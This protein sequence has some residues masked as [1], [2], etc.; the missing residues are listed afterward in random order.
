MPAGKDCD[1][2]HEAQ[3]V[4][5]VRSLKPPPQVASEAPGRSRLQ[6]S[7][8]KSGQG[9]EDQRHVFI[10]YS[11]NTQDQKA[12]ELA[13]QATT[14]KRTVRARCPDS[15][16]PQPGENRLGGVLARG[17][18]LRGGE[19]RRTRGRL[20]EGPPPDGHAPPR[21]LA[22]GR[23]AEV[24]PG[25]GDKVPKGTGSESCPHA[26]EGPDRPE[27]DTEAEMCEEEETRGPESQA[28]AEDA[29]GPR[30]VGPASALLGPARAPH[31][32]F[33]TRPYVSLSLS[34]G[35]GPLW[36]RQASK[37]S[38]AAAA[39]SLPAPP[40]LRFVQPNVLPNLQQ[41]AGSDPPLP[42]F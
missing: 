24:Q 2:A 8:A 12:S 34:S 35:D 40:C 21:V 18:V 16:R 1:S 5:G 37:N 42:L 31:L 23:Q 7:L 14:I 3:A 30:G 22:P 25:P 28:R 39:P 33:C 17:Q 32:V 26:G 6:E 38:L 41:H 27:E 29:S 20:G 19:V 13:K 4:L 11:R 10:R 15:R 36:P 9:W